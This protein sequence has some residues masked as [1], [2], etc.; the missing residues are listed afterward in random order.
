ML[1]LVVVSV[2]VDDQHVLEL[3]LLGLLGGVRQQLGGIQLLDGHA[4]SAIGNQIHGFSPW[5]WDRS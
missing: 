5:G 3:A 1:A 2:D 4:P